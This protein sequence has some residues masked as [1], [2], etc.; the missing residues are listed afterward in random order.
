VLGVLLQDRRVS[1]GGVHSP[2]VADDNGPG[3]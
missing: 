2:T 3:P 1:V